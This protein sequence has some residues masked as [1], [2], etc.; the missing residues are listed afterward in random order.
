MRNTQSSVIL[1][2]IDVYIFITSVLFKY[3]KYPPLI[4]SGTTNVDEVL[5][6]KSAHEVEDAS[7]NLEWVPYRG[8]RVEPSGRGSS[9]LPQSLC[10]DNENE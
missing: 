4:G 7:K 8:R 9:V 10:R 3:V 5:M 1:M 2:V 6:L